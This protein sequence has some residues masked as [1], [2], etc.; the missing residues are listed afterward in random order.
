MAVGNR[1]LG[2]R[3]E[4]RY[5]ITWACNV[6]QLCVASSHHSAATS[7]GDGRWQEAFWESC[8]LHLQ[9]MAVQPGDAVTTFTAAAAMPIAAE[10]TAALLQSTAHCSCLIAASDAFCNYTRCCTTCHLPCA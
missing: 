1:H 2:M 9:S 7:A 5:H 8:C 10:Q 6:L 4:L 3:D